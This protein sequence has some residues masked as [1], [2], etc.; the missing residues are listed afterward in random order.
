MVKLTWLPDWKAYSVRRNGRVIG[1][2]RCSM[3][4]PF[5]VAVEFA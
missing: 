4:L 5:H 3:P 2:V 1:L